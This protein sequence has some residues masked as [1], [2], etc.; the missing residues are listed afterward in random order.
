MLGQLW[1]RELTIKPSD[2]PESG[3][4]LHQQPAHKP[5]SSAPS[6]EHGKCTAEVREAAKIPDNAVKEFE[7]LTKDTIIAGDYAYDTLCKILEVAPSPLLPTTT[8]SA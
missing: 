2:S 6:P 5:S 3:A 8:R 4:C 1:I 7:A